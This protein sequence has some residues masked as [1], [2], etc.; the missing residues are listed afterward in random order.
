MTNVTVNITDIF[1]SKAYVKKLE[2]LLKTHDEAAEKFRKMIEN[3]RYIVDMLKKDGINEEDA[4]FATLKHL[5]D[6]SLQIIYNITALNITSEA[7]KSSI[8]ASSSLAGA[9]AAANAAVGSQALSHTLGIGRTAVE[10]MTRA[11]LLTF[12]KLIK[13]PSMVASGTMSAAEITTSV[14]SGKKTDV[15]RLNLHRLHNQLFVL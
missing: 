6:G 7:I 2:E 4:I 15:S 11:E 3:I 10:G 13:D 5:K 8:I 14:I 12:V 1:K 9:D